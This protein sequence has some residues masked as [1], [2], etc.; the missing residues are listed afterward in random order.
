MP[1]VLSGGGG[2]RGDVGARAGRGGTGGVA[3]EL[4]G[5]VAGD[6]GGEKGWVPLVVMPPRSP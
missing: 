1:G 2:R 3:D 4:V 6:L 5:A